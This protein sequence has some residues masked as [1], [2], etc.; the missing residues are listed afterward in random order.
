MLAEIQRLRYDVYCIECGFL[1]RNNFP[2]ARESDAYDDHA[3]QL[4]AKNA[5]GQV[6]GTARLVLD[7]PLGFPLEAHASGLGHAFHSIPRDRTAEISRLAVAKSGR[8][9]PKA[10]HLHANPLVLFKLFREMGVESRRLGL[11]YWLAS[12]E[13]ALQRLVR[14]LVGFEFV[15]IGEPMDYYGE[16]VPYM[17]SIADIIRTLERDRPEL[18][19]YFGYGTLSGGIPLASPH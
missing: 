1:D 10:G 14:R 4:A 16:V 8:Q 17:A 18:Y 7:S 19:E 11:E 5:D 6:S 9:V 15:Q 12:M 3:I 2:D 13:P